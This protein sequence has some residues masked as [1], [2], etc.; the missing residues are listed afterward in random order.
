MT[1]G[2]LREGGFTVDMYTFA[3]EHSP[4]RERKTARAALHVRERAC[5]W[6]RYHVRRLKPLKG[7]HGNVAA[8]FI[9]RRQ[10]T[11]GTDSCR[12]E[13]LR[14]LIYACTCC[15]R[16]TVHMRAPIYSAVQKL[17]REPS[18]RNSGCGFSLSFRSFVLFALASRCLR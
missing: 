15:T 1:I 16:D 8:S 17:F 5:L 7:G 13:T 18:D 9:L 11:R 12:R 2:S 3:G 10:D 6:A 4:R 14:A